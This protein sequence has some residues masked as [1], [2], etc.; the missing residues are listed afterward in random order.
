MP[1]WPTGTAWPSQRNWPTGTAWPSGTSWPSGSAPPPP[2]ITGLVGY[3]TV[4]GANSQVE[5][6]SITAIA[7]AATALAP[8]GGGTGFTFRDS[9]WNTSLSGSAHAIH[10]IDSQKM[11]AASAPL[12]SAFNGVNKPFTVIDVY[13]D[14]NAGQSTLWSAED[15]FPFVLCLRNNNAQVFDYQVQSTTSH[16]FASI[17][18]QGP[19]VKY[20][21]RTPTAC[22]LYVNNVADSANPVAY[23]DANNYIATKLSWGEQDGTAH[24]VMLHR[25]RLVYNRVLT[26]LERN[27]VTQWAAAL[28][29]LDWC[30]AIGSGIGT[31][32]LDVVVIP[33]LGSSNAAGQGATRYA[34]TCGDVYTIDWDFFMRPVPNGE[35]ISTVAQGVTIP[36][37]LTRPLLAGSDG[38]AWSALADTL[39]ADPQF[40]GKA[41]LF[42]PLG[43]GLFSSTSC[44]QGSG[45]TPRDITTGYGQA[46]HKLQY[47][48]RAKNAKIGPVCI[49]QGEVNATISL[50][51]ATTTLASDWTAFC[52]ALDAD[53]S[54][55]F[56]KALHYI[57]IVPP[58]TVP[59]GIDPTWWAG[60]RTTWNALPGTVTNLA[61]VAGCDGPWTSNGVNLHMD[62]GTASPQT[63]LRG[64]G[65]RVANAYLA[66]P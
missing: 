8:Y 11:F 24:A 64:D 48:L 61:V 59:G 60:M 58:A 51:S 7:D 30:Q 25:R 28:D 43:V 41:L 17:A 65:V 55:K 49:Y 52:A 57:A 54:G 27:S 38:D 9:R 35:P 40:S 36:A 6:G 2:V 63:G 45:T 46:W 16:V 13:Q 21:E 50:A 5:G 1:S 62:T 32:G 47:A 39:K 12:I 15:T 19:H 22:N 4:D 37:S 20:F 33:V 34:R 44:T 23:T 66:A 10:C 53:F 29:G 3:W 31:S 14:L 26:S 18:T 42:V 56:L